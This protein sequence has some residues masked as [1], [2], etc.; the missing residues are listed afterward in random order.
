MSGFSPLEM[1]VP[2][3]LACWEARMD[4]SG[5]L[6]MSA[7]ELNRLEVLRRV[8]ERR[9]T[10]AQAAEQLGLG[11]RQVERLCRMLRLEGPRGLISKKREQP[12]NR[13]L[14]EDLRRRALE[15]VQPHYGDFGP[16]LAAEKLA[17]V[18]GVAVPVETLRRW[19]IEELWVP[20][21]Q[22]RRVY[23]PRHRRSCVGEL[24]A[25]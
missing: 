2:G 15:R 14:S 3:T 20:R 23:Q 11:T 10:Q 18:H 4:D 13:K 24:L 6:T 17:A 5:C 8:L 12:S 19:M 25:S 7:K 9:L 22:R 16:T 21:A 1:S